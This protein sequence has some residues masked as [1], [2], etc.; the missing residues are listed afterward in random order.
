MKTSI[1]L[2]SLLGLALIAGAP[3]SHAADTTTPPPADGPRPR[4]KEMREHR[5]TM[6]DEK[7]HLTPEQ[8]TQIQQIWDKAEQQMRAERQ[9]AVKADEDRREKRRAAM[10]GI[11]A[12]IRAVLTPEQQKIFDQTP[13]RGGP[14]EGHRGPSKG[15]DKP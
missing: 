14:R 7:L 12:E 11:H 2:L 15:D 6:L 13:Q 1:K 4:M 3:V 10:Q 9:A 5:M 8:K